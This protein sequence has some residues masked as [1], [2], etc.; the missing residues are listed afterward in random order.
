[1]TLPAPAF[2]DSA[3]ASR[4]FRVAYD[5]RAR[6]AKAWAAEHGVAPAAS[7]RSRTALLSWTFRT[8]FACRDTSCSLARRIFLLDDCSSAVVVPGVA[9]FTDPAEEAYRRFAAAGMHRVVSTTPMED[10]D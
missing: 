2:F 5:E 8:P 1:M 10:W 7:D 6:E 9:D 4:V 3:S